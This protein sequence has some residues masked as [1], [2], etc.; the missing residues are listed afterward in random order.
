M[1]PADEEDD[2]DWQS[3][4][5]EAYLQIRGGKLGTKGYKQKFFRMRENMLVMY[6]KQKSKSYG[7]NS[8]TIYQKGSVLHAL[9]LDDPEYAQFKTQGDAANSFVVVCPTRL[10]RLAAKT[11]SARDD[12]VKAINTHIVG[13]ATTIRSSEYGFMRAAA[14]LRTLK[15]R[16]RS[17]ILKQATHIHRMFRSLEL[18]CR[19]DYTVAKVLERVEAAE[20]SGREV[21]L[22][23]AQETQEAYWLACEAVDAI[24]AYVD[25]D[26]FL[27]LFEQMGMASHDM[28][29]SDTQV[30]YQSEVHGEWP[31]HATYSNCCSVTSPCAHIALTCSCV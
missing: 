25:M 24:K 23:S 31:T 12:W 11:A 6:K 4:I 26:G 29:L 8:G 20:A 7:K 28:Q 19:R 18:E 21:D 22:K 2:G 14:A 13:S 30:A 27:G 16:G 1:M 3:C 10:L 5:L 9:S 15:K 17:S